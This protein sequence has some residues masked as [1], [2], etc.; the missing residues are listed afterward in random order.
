MTP[1]LPIKKTTPGAPCKYVNVV[2]NCWSISSYGYLPFKV[3][4]GS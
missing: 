2:C 4:A 3:L 1:H